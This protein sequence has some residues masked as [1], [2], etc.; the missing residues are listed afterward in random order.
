MFAIQNFATRWHPRHMFE[1]QHWPSSDGNLC[2]KPCGGE[3][4]KTL[5]ALHLVLYGTQVCG[6][7]N[8][9]WGPKTTPITMDGNG[10]KIRTFQCW[11]VLDCRDVTAMCRGLLNGWPLSSPGAASLSGGRRW[12]NQPLQKSVIASNLESIFLSKRSLAY[13]CNFRAHLQALM[14]L[15]FMPHSIGVLENMKKM[16]TKKK[17]EIVHTTFFSSKNYSWIWLST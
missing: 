17:S 10:T 2:P 5:Q 13:C 9:C 16:W 6:T 11:R 8:K 1:I 7:Q 3:P 12:K 4:E 14:F 15:S